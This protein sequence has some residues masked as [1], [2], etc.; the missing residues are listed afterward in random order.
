MRDTYTVKVPNTL[1]GIKYYLFQYI[2]DKIFNDYLPDSFIKM[3]KKI[4]F[5]N[6]LRIVETQNCFAKLI[7]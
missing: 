5:D 2:F 6:I 1:L 7:L 3:K 4:I